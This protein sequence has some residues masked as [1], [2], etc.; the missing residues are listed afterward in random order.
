ME[1]VARPSQL[2]A[3]PFEWSPQEPSGFEFEMMNGVIRIFRGPQRDTEAFPL[4]GNSYDFFSDMHWWVTACVIDV[5]MLAAC[6]H[7]RWPCN[8]GPGV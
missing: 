8:W 2:E 7:I 1:E 4:P 3:K 6:V 5:C